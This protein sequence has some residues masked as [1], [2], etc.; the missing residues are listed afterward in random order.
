ML[1]LDLSGLGLDLVATVEGHGPVKCEGPAVG[2]VC[3]VLL[4]DLIIQGGGKL[5]CQLFFGFM[6]FS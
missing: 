6:W 1:S 5:L 3:L 4:T 2:R